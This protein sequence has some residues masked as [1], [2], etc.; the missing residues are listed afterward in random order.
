M[1][2]VADCLRLAGQ[3]QDVSDTPRLDIEVMLGRILQVERSWLYTWPESRLTEAQQ[4]E[5]QLQ[6][7]RRKQGEPVAHITGEREFWSL[8]LKVDSTTLIPRPETETLVEKAL[9]LPLPASAA[10]LDLGTGTGAIALALAVERPGWQVTAVDAVPEAVA[11]AQHNAARHHLQNVT[12]TE[13]N[14]FSCLGEQR[15]DLIVSNPPYIDQS[16]PHLREGDVRFE[17]AS[18][19]VAGENGCADLR[20]IIQSAGEYLRAG[21]WLLLEHGYQQGETVRK[22]LLSAGYD[23]VETGLDLAGC[24]RISFGQ[25]CP[26]Q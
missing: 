10:V 15:F 6:L 12:V 8:T 21:G 25:L 22:L 14:W 1:T 20:R 4:T 11:L 18:A 2:T 16:D 26:R 9:Q 13:S 24:E 5:F 19:L 23:K 17:P 3:L 7:Q